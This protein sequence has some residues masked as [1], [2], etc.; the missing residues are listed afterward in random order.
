MSESLVGKKVKTKHLI[1]GKTI[2]E[3]E[4]IGI[5][6]RYYTFMGKEYVNIQYEDTPH[7]YTT[8][9]EDVEVL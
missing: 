9:L 2:R 6:K 3:I 8:K 5:I 1:L 7:W 4:K